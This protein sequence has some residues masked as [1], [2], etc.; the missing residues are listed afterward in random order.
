MRIR[1]PSF[2]NLSV[3]PWLL[4][5]AM[6]ADVVAILASLDFVMGECDR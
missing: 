3:L 2:V 1:G 4:R 5:G 6:L